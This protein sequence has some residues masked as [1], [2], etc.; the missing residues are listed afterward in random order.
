MTLSPS[1][2]ASITGPLSPALG[3]AEPGSPRNVSPPCEDNS[4]AHRPPELPAHNPKTVSGGTK[5]WGHCGYCGHF[6]REDTEALA[7]E[8]PC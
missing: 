7:S 5:A 1:E 8:G 2:T 3:E 4:R 6:T